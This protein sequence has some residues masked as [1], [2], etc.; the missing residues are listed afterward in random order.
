MIGIIDEPKQ[1]DSR[2]SR[3]SNNAVCYYGYNGQKYP[4]GGCEGDG[5]AEG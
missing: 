4:S 2:N 3:N 1:R 5:F